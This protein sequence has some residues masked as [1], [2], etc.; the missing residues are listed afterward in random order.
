MLKNNCKNLQVL[1][2][3]ILFV[4]TANATFAQRLDTLV[5]VGGYK[6]HFNIFKGKG[7]PILFEAGSNA[8]SSDWDTILPAIYKVTGT[9]L[10]TYDS[11]MSP[12]IKA[13]G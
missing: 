8:W 5:D 4:I 3:I 6:L 9:T 11:I 10:I 13:E 1:K 2:I 7:T 12:I